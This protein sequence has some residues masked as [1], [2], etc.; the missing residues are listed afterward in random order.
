MKAHSPFKLGMRFQLSLDSYYFF[1]I[2][3]AK[4][5]PGAIL[6]GIISKLDISKEVII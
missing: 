2:E 6:T 4:P 3:T 5:P 1:F